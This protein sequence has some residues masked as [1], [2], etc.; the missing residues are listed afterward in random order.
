MKENGRR[1]AF[2]QTWTLIQLL[3]SSFLC[4]SNH[5][6]DCNHMPWK[7]CVRQIPIFHYSCKI[8]F[9]IILSV[10]SNG[11]HIHACIRSKYRRG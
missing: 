8:F 11:D 7:L 2:G 5:G 9:I 3:F 6:N 10:F 1:N 4:L